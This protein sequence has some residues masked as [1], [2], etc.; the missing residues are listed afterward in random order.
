MHPLKR[1]YRVDG[2][3][4]YV[5]Y[6]YNE[7]LER[8]FFRYKEQ[9]DIALAKWFLDLHKEWVMRICAGKRCHIAP[10]GQSQ[11]QRRGFEPLL[12]MMEACQIPVYSSLIKQEDFKQ[13]SLSKAD[14]PKAALQIQ[15]KQWYPPVPCDVLIEIIRSTSILAEMHIFQGLADTLRRISAVSK[16]FFATRAY[17]RPGVP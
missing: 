11:R 13:S 17:L 2:C 6:E 14:R 16:G 15:K 12:R 8:M 7:F 5:L 3:R 4:Y 10:S 1:V 9:Q